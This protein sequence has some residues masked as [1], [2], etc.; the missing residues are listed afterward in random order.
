MFS[1]ILRNEYW[2]RDRN[3]NPFLGR[4]REEKDWNG[5]EVVARPKGKA[6]KALTLKSI[7][8]RT[9]PVEL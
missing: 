7:L 4:K 6:P 8:F 3:R 1:H 9:L 2:L 5:D